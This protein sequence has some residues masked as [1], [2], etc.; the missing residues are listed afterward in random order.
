MTDDTDF[1]G[2]VVS[3]GY[4]QIVLMPIVV[5][6]TVLCLVGWA[7]PRLV[8]LPLHISPYFLVA[9]S[10][11][12]QFSCYRSQSHFTTSFDSAVGFDAH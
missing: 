10:K 7:Y 11:E 1:D 8:F 6:T 12:K 9:S 5:Q 3:M 2:C 4:A